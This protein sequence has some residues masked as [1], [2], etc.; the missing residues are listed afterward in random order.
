MFWTSQ[1]LQDE[2]QAKQEPMIRRFC[3]C[4]LEVTATGASV[5]QGRPLKGKD[6][7]AC[8]LSKLGCANGAGT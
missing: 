5:Q 3:I 7:H 8:G 2:T 1:L 6:V 4:M